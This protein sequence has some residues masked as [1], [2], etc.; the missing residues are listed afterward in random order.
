[1]EIA[2][3]AEQASGRLR[4]LAKAAQESQISK[5]GEA[6]EEAAAKIDPL[7]EQ[8]IEQLRAAKTLDTLGKVERDWLSKQEQFTKWAALLKAYV[9]GQENALAE[10]EGL[11]A[12]WE[13]T[14]DEPGFDGL[15][16]K[17]RAQVDETQEA[18]RLAAAETGKRLERARL[19]KGGVDAAAGRIRSVLDLLRIEADEFRAR[20]L[21]F[22]SPPLWAV[23]FDREEAG[24]LFHQFRGM[25]ADERDSLVDWVARNRLLM[26]VHFLG[27]VALCVLLLAVRRR[28]PRDRTE[29]TALRPA[30]RVIARPVAA[31]LLLALLATVWIYPEAPHTVDLVNSFVAA[32]PLLW[33]LAGIVR[34]RGVLYVL[35]AFF[36]VDR[37]RIYADDF[38]LLQRILILSEA[39]IGLVAMSAF[40]RL[41]REVQAG[42][43]QRT[44][45]SLSRLAQVVLVAAVIADL[46]GAVGL[47][48]LI[49]GG[50]LA[51]LYIGALFY[52]GAL[53]L[54]VLL[55]ELLATRAARSLRMVRDHEALLQR[56]VLKTTIALSIV[57]WA[58]ATLHGFSVWD[59]VARFVSAVLGASVTVGKLHVSLGGVLAL[60]LVIWATILISRLIR[61]ILNEDVMPRLPLPHGVPAAISTIVHYVVL[62][63]GFFFAIAA[64][65]LDLSKLA[66]LVGAFGV[67]IGFGLQNIVNNFVSGLILLFERPIKVG[68]WVEL[69]ALYGEVKRIGIRSST[70]R[71][72]EGADVIVPNGSLLDSNVINWT[73]SDRRRRLKVAVGVAYGTDVARVMELLLEVGR[74]QP[75]VLKNPEP[76]VLFVG[77]GE[78]SL[79]F[80]LRVWV[81]QFQD[82]AATRSAVTVEVNRVLQENSIEIPFPQRD[83]HLRS[84]D[85]DVDL[86]GAKV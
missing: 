27:T 9:A 64:A 5:I 66:F 59:P 86:G 63:I 44:L 67:G 29:E 17:K 34:A 12:Q 4:A 46:I 77:F 6:A 49:V 37:L 84:V 70:I 2:T 50:T 76:D 32:I 7:A 72:V 56:R 43:W 83:L 18:L 15:E 21:T 60:A 25:S 55:T 23:L 78:S 57:A 51:S 71:T 28:M 54:A 79:D 11:Q 80:E 48:N 10:L 33:I 19:W 16:A 8:A 65:G 45:L 68:D 40:R 52:V 26:V 75:Q 82:G 35:A 53:V 31:A 41:A 61:F 36:V 1:V 22:D 24:S 30:A 38:S 62:L 58:V 42:R 81:G 3:R 20:L 39:V 14:R 47:A 13:A 69:N 73:H 74:N 85:P